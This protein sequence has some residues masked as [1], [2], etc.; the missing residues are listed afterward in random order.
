MCNKTN[1]IIKIYNFIR[2]HENYES[3]AL[4]MSR[5]LE[6]KAEKLQYISHLTR[7]DTIILM[8]KNRCIKKRRAIQRKLI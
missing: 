2:K 4:I 6:R 3:L 7:N 1:R 8:G 5:Q